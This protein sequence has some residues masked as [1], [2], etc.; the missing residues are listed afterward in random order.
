MT[1]F[2]EA[3]AVMIWGGPSFRHPFTRS[4]FFEDIYWGRLE[5][6]SLRDPSAMLAGFGQLY[7]RDGRVHLARLVVKPTMRGEGIGK[8]LINMLMTAGQSR[9]PGDEF[10]LF[11]FRDNMPAYE[12]YKSMGFVVSD[13]PDDMPHADVCYYL[14]KRSQSWSKQEGEENDE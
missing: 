10:S 13:Y 6:F 11:V 14:I 7:D 8:R 12:C 5:S 9:V 4:T 1:W 2:P 3:D